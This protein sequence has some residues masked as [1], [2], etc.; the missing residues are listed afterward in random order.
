MSLKIKIT[1]VKGVLCA[2]YMYLH[3]ML[4]ILI[5]VML[6]YE[7]TWYDVVICL[8]THRLIIYT[9]VLVV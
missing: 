7:V 1:S 6:C 5:Y 8:L 3:I 4:I 2:N 9:F